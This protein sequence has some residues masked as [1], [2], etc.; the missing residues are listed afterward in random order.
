MSSA[1]RDA[2]PD[3]RSRDE[4]NVGHAFLKKLGTRKVAKEEQTFKVEESLP[5]SSLKG[6]S[7]RPTTSGLMNA[8]RRSAS[9]IGASIS[10]IRPGTSLLQARP[11]S[12]F[13]SDRPPPQM[14]S[15]DG[16][17]DG[18]ARKNSG[19]VHRVSA[20]SSLP[21]PLTSMGLTSEHGQGK[22]PRSCPCGHYGQLPVIHNR[23]DPEQVGLEH[24]RLNKHVYTHKRSVW[25]V[26]VHTCM[27]VQGYNIAC[28]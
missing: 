9:S 18:L 20:A 6:P 28:L 26:E 23:A 21:R 1:K 12:Q 4:P 5:S 3:A 16:P 10:Q 19:L 2:V 14:L 13:G 8:R 11:A 25:S 27:G 22:C 24:T 15:A 7:E 17:N